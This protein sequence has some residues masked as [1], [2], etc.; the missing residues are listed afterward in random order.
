MLSALRSWILGIV[1]AGVLCGVCR[2]LAPEGGGKRVMGVVCGFVMMLAVMSILRGGEVPDIGKYVS[3]YTQEAGEITGYARR[4]GA[5][6]TRFIIE[7]RLEAY[8]LDK[9][10]ALGLELRDVQVTARW[11]EDGCWVPVE[12]VLRGDE[13]AELSRMIESELGIARSEQIWSTKDG[14]ER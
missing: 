10:A 7:A 9:A 8:I 5:A 6:Q 1:G 13:S 2:A 3:R 12:C 4:E 11:S 14:Q